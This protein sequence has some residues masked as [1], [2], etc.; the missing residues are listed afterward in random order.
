MAFQTGWRVLHHDVAMH[1]AEQLLLA[2]ANVR[3][4][5][6]DVDFGLR[7]LRRELARHWRHG[8]PWRAHQALEIIGV[9][10]MATWAALTALIAEFPVLLANVTRAD[11]TPVLAV[12][13]AAYSFIASNEDV[14]SVDR[15]LQDLPACL[16]A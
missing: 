11:A 15:F 16:T 5:D 4:A 10:D 8:A 6:R 7:V 3:C 14:A 9:L 12:D 2:I 1:A 13:P